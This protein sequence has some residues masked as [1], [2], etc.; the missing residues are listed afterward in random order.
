V[1]AAK[2]LGVPTN[3]VKVAN[4][5]LTAVLAGLAGCIQFARFHSVDPMRGFGI[6]L[7]VIA[8][9]VIGGTTFTGGAG[10]VVGT[11]FGVLIMGMVRSGLIQA[12]APAYWYQT[13]VGLIILLACAGNE[14]LM[15]WV[16][17]K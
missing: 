8:A 2:A 17:K 14:R 13:F 4:F 10:S 5:I 6:E 3:R 12:G 11:I 15:R 16:V 7:E 1:Q 9:V